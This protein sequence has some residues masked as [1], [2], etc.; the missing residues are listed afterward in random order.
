MRSSRRRAAASGARR[1][2]TSVPVTRDDQRVARRDLQRGERR[3][4][5]LD[6]A[7]EAIR[8]LGAAATMEQLAR[9]GGVTK[10]ILYRHFGDREGL[11]GA[12]AERFS[13]ELLGQ[14]EAALGSS[15][16]PREILDRTVDAYLAFIERDPALYRFLLQQAVTPAGL[17][18]ISPLVGTVARQVATVLGGQ[19]QAAGKDSGAAVPWAFGMVGLVHQAGDWWLEDRTMS[20]E[21]LVAYLT[22]LIWSGLDTAAAPLAAQRDA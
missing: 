13:L 11:V 17:V 20:R 10:P 5:L 19:L 21:R 22:D 7:I 18:H 6:A 2:V 9:R 4:Q 14:V 12:I 15:A 8:D 16:A 1:S 3:A